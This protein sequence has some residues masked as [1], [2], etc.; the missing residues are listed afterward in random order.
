MEFQPVRPQT[1]SQKP[2]PAPTKPKLL[3]AILCLHGGGSNSTVFTIQCRRLI[4]NLK[5]QFRFVFVQGPLLS[6]PGHGMLPV[7]ESVSPFYRW[8]TKKYVNN[9]VPG[10]K[11]ETPKDEIEDIDY[12][13]RHT[14]EENGGVDS[15]VGLIGFSMGARMVAGLLLRQLVEERND[16]TCWTKFK[17][18]VMVG[19]PYP[20]ISMTEKVDPKDY[21]LFRTIPTVHAWGRNDHVKSGC[22]ELRKI[23]EG[24]VCFQMDF[25][26]GH[27]M[28][29]SDAEARDLSD[30]IRGAYYA[31]GG[32][33]QI[34]GEETY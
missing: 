16:G 25:E 20:P 28:P 24:D 11:E 6:D 7:F 19:G 18:G 30:L 8:V 22:E 32:E 31:G 4:W 26:G 21:E 17:F 9:I 14:M 10:D 27:H 2:A 15:F 12:L 3:P 33:F 34:G 5:S 23:C 29:L 13:I 1:Y